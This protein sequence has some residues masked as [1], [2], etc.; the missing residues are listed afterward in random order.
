MRTIPAR[1]SLTVE[2]KS[3]HRRLPDGELMATEV[4]RAN[5]EGGEI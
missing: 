4:C 2:L 5:T 1:G 3:D